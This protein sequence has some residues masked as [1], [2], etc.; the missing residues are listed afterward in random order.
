MFQVERE[1][2]SSRHVPSDKTI[3]QSI[4]KAQNLVPPSESIEST[5]QQQS[6]STSPYTSSVSSSIE[7]FNATQSLDV[8]STPSVDHTMFNNSALVQP[9]QQQMSHTVADISY[10][11][12]PSTSD[13]EMNLSNM[14]MT[15]T[16][17]TKRC[18][19]LFEETYDDSF[20]TYTDP[21]DETFHPSMFTESDDSLTDE[22]IH[23][24]NTI[25][26]NED[27][28]AA[29]EKFTDSLLLISFTALWTLLSTR[30]CSIC[31]SKFKPIK[32]FRTGT[33]ITVRSIC[34]E[35]GHLENWESQEK[36][37]DQPIGNVT[38]AASMFLNGISF[39]TFKKFAETLNLLF[40]SKT[41]Y[42]NL[43][44]KYI[45]PVIKCNWFMQRKKILSEIS[46]SEK[47]MLAGDG[48]HDSPGFSAKYCV[49]SVMDCVT[50]YIVDFVVVQ[51]GICKEVLEK[52]GCD[53][54]LDRLHKVLGKKLF[55]FVT[56]RHR[57]IGKLLRE[58]YPT[59]IH[60]FDVWHIAKGL[61]KKLEKVCE[62]F[63]ILRAWKRSII[64]HLW[65]SINNC[66]ENSELLVEKFLSI[67]KH[68]QNI[69]KWKGGS[70]V[71]QCSHGRLPN[72]NVRGKIWLNNHAIHNENNTD[73]EYAA[74]E[75]I[76]TNK[77]FL[78]DLRQARLS[79]HT[80]SLESYHNE[81]LMFTPKRIHFPYHGMVMRSILGV[82]DTEEHL[83]EEK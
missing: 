60:S 13:F 22:S 30:C 20:T 9:P 18:S 52:Y 12:V 77:M 16:P 37:K 54:I 65:W 81:R 14:H 43:L 66:E 51:K 67:L 64:N 4:C 8:V 79:Q 33:M 74:L 11:P 73:S 36:V 17:K 76:L 21:C 70:F 56:D 63:T 1:L 72:S 59:I 42:N 45:Y 82:L 49:Y 23:N 38:L 55:S 34:A 28:E 32:A 80:G 7:T 29:K 68:V 83:R 3:F 24:R 62:K 2:S 25:K 26:E 41:A 5:A 44:K 71:T 27:I 15:S 47:V 58:K 75:E 53:F 39:E 50:S 40:L 35:N 6:Q 46:K 57:G 69:H 61:S 31:G 10:E 48:Q 19:A 78:K